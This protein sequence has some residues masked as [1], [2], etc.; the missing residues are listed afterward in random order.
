MI[1]KVYAKKADDIKGFE[2]LWNIVFNTI[3]TDIQ[4]ISTGI[5]L[6]LFNVKFRFNDL[7]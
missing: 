4:D 5:L 1:D 6:N 3:N 7:V 2:C